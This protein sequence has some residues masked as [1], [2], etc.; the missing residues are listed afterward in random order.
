MC[1]GVRCVRVGRCA[2][3][4]FLSCFWI[5]SSIL[6]PQIVPS[7][8]QVISYQLVV[9]C[10]ECFAGCVMP[11]DS[12]C[13]CLVTRPRALFAPVFRWCSWFP[14]MILPLIGAQNCTRRALCTILYQLICSA[15]YQVCV[16]GLFDSREV[17]TFDCCLEYFLLSFV[18]V[19]YP[20]SLVIGRKSCSKHQVTLHKST[21]HSRWIGTKGLWNVLPT[22][23]SFPFCFRERLGN[24]TFCCL[25]CLL[26]FN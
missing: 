8:L 16:V 26:I 22:N 23:S 9:C 6:W 20:H 4:W 24:V 14:P 7:V 15:A 2:R 11:L 13:F 25:Y 3:F 10:Q 1:F 19:L 21:K 18:L 5:E 17:I 12:A